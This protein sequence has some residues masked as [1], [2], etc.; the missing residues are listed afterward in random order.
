MVS[1]SYSEYSDMTECVYTCVCVC[2][3]V[4]A[5]SLHHHA[6]DHANQLLITWVSLFIFLHVGIGTQELSKRSV[7]VDELGVAPHFCDLAVIHHYN[8]VTLGE[9]AYAVRHQDT[10][11]SGW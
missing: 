2:V 4:C 11:L 1:S 7:I 8:L 9:E 5:G 10:R 3:C 6:I